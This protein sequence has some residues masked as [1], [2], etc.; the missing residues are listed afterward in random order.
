MEYLDETPFRDRLTSAEALIN[1]LRG[2]KT[3]TEIDLIRK[4]VEITETIF[5]EAKG[6]VKSGMKETEIYDF[7]HERMIQYNVGDAWSPDHNPAVD[8]G[9][10]KQFGHSGPTKNRTKDGHLLHF[11]FGV[12]WKG[13]CSDI[14]RMFFFGA[15][16]DVPAEVQDAF[17]AVRDCIQAASE[18]LRPGRLGHEV[19][20]VARDFVKDR[21]Y[22]EYQHALGHQVGRNAHD[23]GTLLGPLWERYGESPNGVVE[24][25]NVFTLELYVTTKGYG[26][27]SLEEDVLV[28]STG[29]EFLSHPQK[30]LICIE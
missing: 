23:G 3:N 1:G 30:E 25:G 26:Q 12:K 16:T 19:D 10:N 4:A 22:D 5:D 20:S 2:R 9:P 29:C 24:E 18:F 8:A 28:T 6:F 14:Q 27:V 13:Y 21:G 7:F 11:D 17:S 15:P